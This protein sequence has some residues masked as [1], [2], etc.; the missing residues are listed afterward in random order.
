MNFIRVIAFQSQTRQQAMST[1]DNV[2]DSVWLTIG[3]T[4]MILYAMRRVI[5]LFLLNDILTCDKN[6][7]WESVG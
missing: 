1:K 5:F 2:D 7:L 3:V 4:L 6:F